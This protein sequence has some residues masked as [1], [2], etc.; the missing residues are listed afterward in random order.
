MLTIYMLHSCG[1]NLRSSKLL[2]IVLG[3]WIILFPVLVM[4]PF[5]GDFFYL[6]PENLYARGPRYPLFILLVIVIPLLTLAGTI[7]RR[8]WL[9]RKVFLA[10]L[11]AIV[12]F[13]NRY[14]KLLHPGVFSPDHNC[15]L[16]I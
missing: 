14:I 5:I 4:S 2:R 7:K 1:E 11:I 15:R 13:L 9:S 8:K 12:S 10:F 16:L 3:I 6:M